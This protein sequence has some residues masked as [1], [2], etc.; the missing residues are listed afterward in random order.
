MPATRNKAAEKA[1]KPGV[2]P[3]TPYLTC[4]HTAEAMHFYKRTFGAKKLMAP[5]TRSDDKVI[6]ATLSLN[7]SWVRLHDDYS[8]AR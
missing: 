7:M 3:V 4:K 5:L 1:A 6:H 8:L 2:S